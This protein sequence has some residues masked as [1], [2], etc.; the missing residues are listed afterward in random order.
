[1]ATVNQAYG[2]YTALTVTHLQSLANSAT[3]GWQSALIDNQ[4][5]VKAIDYEITVSLP[6][7]N[8]APS[9]PSDVQV[10]IAPAMTTDGGTTWLISDQGTATLPGKTEAATTIATPSNNLL[11]LGLL[12]YA[13][14]N[15]TMQRTFL[16]SSA[17]GQSMP[18]G[19]VI[20]IIN[21]SGA[22]LSTGCVVAYRSITQT[23]A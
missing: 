16:L 13:T 21:N 10:Y 4:T 9:S 3:A 8:T 18:D 7:A 17:V 2:T 5:S 20:I 12:S 19:F 23:V 1:M 11:L 22:A 15:M 6:T 14:Q